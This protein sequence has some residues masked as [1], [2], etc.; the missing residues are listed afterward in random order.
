MRLSRCRTPLRREEAPALVDD[1]DQVEGPREAFDLRPGFVGDAPLLV[2]CGG[3]R[4]Q[5]QAPRS[6][7][8]ERRGSRSAAAP[9]G[10]SPPRRSPPA[11]RRGDHRRF[12]RGRLPPA[13]TGLPPRRAAPEDG[14]PPAL[15]PRLGGCPPRRA[16]GSR[17]PAADHDCPSAASAISDRIPRKARQNCAGS[18]GTSA[19]ERVAPGSVR[20]TL[21]AA[22]RGEM[23]LPC[24]LSLAFRRKKERTRN[25]RKTPLPSGLSKR[26][27]ISRSPLEGSTTGET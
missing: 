26:T 3:V 4:R 14:P 17:A 22:P 5:K 8:C 1:D 25:P 15:R 11:A 21:P 23:P 7:P 13:R 18:P 6:I 24:S 20:M 10:T 16:T 19:G 27:L 12:P 2:A 9:R